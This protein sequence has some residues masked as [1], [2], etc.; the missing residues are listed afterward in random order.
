[1][2]KTVYTVLAAMSL[3]TTSTMAAAAPAPAS[4]ITPLTQPATENVAGDNQLIGSGIGAI[5]GVVVVAGLIA[6]IV[7]AIKS[8]DKGNKPPVVTSP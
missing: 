6:T 7:F 4:V 2:K 8:G 3:V 5:F 1:M